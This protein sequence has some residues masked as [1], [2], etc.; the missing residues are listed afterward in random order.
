MLTAPRAGAVALILGSRLGI[1]AQPTFIFLMF[2][3]GTQNAWD[4]LIGSDGYLPG[5]SAD[6]RPDTPEAVG[7]G[8]R[9][10]VVV[11]D[12]WQG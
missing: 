1:Y 6:E 3:V 11:P 4:L 5:T 8:G 9:S 2:I 7:S 10:R 12:R